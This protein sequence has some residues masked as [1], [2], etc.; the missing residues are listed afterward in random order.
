MDLRSRMTAEG[1]GGDLTKIRKL[2]CVRVGSRV[3]K[4]GTVTV[5]VSVYFLCNNSDGLH[6]VWPQQAR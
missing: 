5:F 3:S 4:E 2:N 1:S 6:T